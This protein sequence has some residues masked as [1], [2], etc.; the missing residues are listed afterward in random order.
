MKCG[1]NLITQKSER[2]EKVIK[3]RGSDSALNESH[4][5]NWRFAVSKFVILNS[6]E[7][8]WLEVSR[9]IK[10]I[11]DP[12]L[13]ESR[14]NDLKNEFLLEVT[15]PN[16]EFISRALSSKDHER[17]KWHSNLLNG[18]SLPSSI[19]KDGFNKILGYHIDS[20]NK[21]CADTGKEISRFKDDTEKDLVFGVYSRFSDQVKDIVYEGNL[22]DINCISDFALARD[23]VAGVL[24]NFSVEVHNRFHDYKKSYEIITEAV[25]CAASTY[26]KQ[27]F[28][29]DVEAVRR[30]LVTAE[31]HKEQ[32]P[33]SKGAKDI[34]KSIPWWVWVIGFFVVTS[35]FS[36]NNS[37]KSSSS[38]TPLTSYK[39]SGSASLSALKTRIMAL[40]S[41]VENK[42]AQLKDLAA[43]IKSKESEM[44]SLKSSI[45]SVESQYKYST[46]GV[47]SDVE[48]DYNSK[49]DEYNN[50]LLPAYNNLLS[51]ARD[52]YSEYEQEVKTHDALVESYNRQIK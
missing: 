15:E 47:P 4:W 37:T 28:E 49:V 46:Y 13:P 16:L 42:E 33:T 23:N 14:I 24:R 48:A 41:S 52:L 8:F 29:K 10:N 7:Y 30:S 11:N 19:L 36:N 44:A 2:K 51:Q 1:V 39:S 5:K 32:A 25:E 12:R 17:T 6:S 40:K 27:R 26:L 20:L 21:Y 34:L 18:F 3:S 50:V 35:L 38:Y 22:V 31:A 45:E 43:Q 9:M